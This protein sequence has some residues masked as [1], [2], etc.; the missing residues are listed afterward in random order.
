MNLTPFLI[1]TP[2]FAGVDES[3]MPG[4]LDCLGAARRTLAREEILLLRGARPDFVGIVLSGML[5]IVK[6]DIEGNRLLVAAMESGDLFAEAL[7]CAGVDESPVTI[8]AETESEVLL[9]HFDRVLRYCPKNCACHQT[10]IAN[11]LRLTAQKNLYL[12]NRL[13]IAGQRSIRAKVMR[14]L[15]GFRAQPGAPFTIPYNREQ[16]AEFLC[17]DRTALSHELARMKQE[18]LLDYQKNRF[19]VHRTLPE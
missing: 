7:C 1:Y 2:L 11:L 15:S 4:L 3:E 14:Y 8:L 6:E 9:L 5:H 13:E 18:G 12:Q 10:V 17:V 16:L 19:T